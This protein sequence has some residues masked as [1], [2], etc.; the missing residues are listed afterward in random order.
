MHLCPL[1]PHLMRA[2]CLFTFGFT[3]RRDA[4]KAPRYLSSLAVAGSPKNLDF[5]GAF[6]SASI[7]SIPAT[8]FA[9]ASGLANHPSFTLYTKK[10]PSKAI[11]LAQSK[12]FHYLCNRK[13]K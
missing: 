10:S 6:P 5:W 1:A 7:S 2:L 11:F 12:I 3:P 9:L 8:C 13:P 4:S